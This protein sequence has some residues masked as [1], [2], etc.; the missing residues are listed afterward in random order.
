MYH[1]LSFVVF[2]FFEAEIKD[3]GVQTSPIQQFSQG[4]QIEILKPSA[5]ISVIRRKTPSLNLALSRKIYP[6][7]ANENPMTKPIVIQI[8]AK[9]HRNFSENSEATTTLL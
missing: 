1:N 9:I 2:K 7:F 8:L 3:W 6:V 4:V 5:S